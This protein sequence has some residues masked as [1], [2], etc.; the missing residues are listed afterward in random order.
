MKSKRREIQVKQEKQVEQASKMAVKRE[1]R[2]KSAMRKVF[3]LCCY[4]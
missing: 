1:R 3:H 4:G 2:G